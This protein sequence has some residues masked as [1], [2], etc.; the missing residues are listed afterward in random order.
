MATEVR[1]E[2]TANVW[3]VRTEVG[4]QVQEG[5]ELVIL[6]SMKMEIPVVA[7]SDGTISEV[8]VAPMTRSRR[9]TSSRDRLV[10]VAGLRFF[11]AARA[12]FARQS[13]LRA[14]RQRRPNSVREDALQQLDRLGL[15]LSAAGSTPTIVKN[16]GSGRRS[17]CYDGNAEVAQLLGV[18]L[19]LVAQRIELGGDDCAGGAFARTASPAKSGDI[20]GCVTSAPSSM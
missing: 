8:R 12:R 2:I 5:D 18:R 13:V 6:E 16:R 14:R 11:R 19:A 1:A 20:S 15:R 4:A 7:P 3:Q 17:E 9:A 10:F